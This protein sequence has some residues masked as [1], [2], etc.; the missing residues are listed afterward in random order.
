L[1]I[2]RFIGQERLN[3]SDNIGQQRVRTFEIMCLSRCQMKAGR[4]AKR[5]A[6]GVDFGGQSPF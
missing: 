4:L 1:R 2:I 6:R 3:I 5:I